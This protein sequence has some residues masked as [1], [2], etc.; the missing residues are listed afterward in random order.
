MASASAPARAS[1]RVRAQSV[2]ACSCALGCNCY[3]GGTPNEGICEFIIGYD[4]QEG[5]LGD[6]DLRGVRAVVA[7]KYPNA[8]HEGHGHVVLFVDPAA[9]PEQ[10]SALVTILSGQAGGMPWE[11]IAAT[12]E[13]FEGPVMRPIEIGTDGQRGHVRIVGAVEVETTPIRNPLAGGEEIEVHMVYPKGGIL[14]NDGNIV[15]TSTMQVT[16]DA[17]QMRW[18]GKFAVI[19]EVSWTNSA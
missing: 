9:T 7:A 19:A 12:I 5:R 4:I 6:V 16:H 11:A 15:T 8:I 1:Y 14:W 10:V 17:L 18:P 13:K 3:F 2:E